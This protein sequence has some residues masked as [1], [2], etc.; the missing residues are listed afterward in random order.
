MSKPELTDST[1]VIPCSVG[2]LIEWENL[3]TVL[4]LL[5]TPGK[6]IMI[7]SCGTIMHRSIHII[8]TL[9]K[10]TE[11]LELVRSAF[12]ELTEWVPTQLIHFPGHGGPFGQEQLGTL[13]WKQKPTILNQLPFKVNQA[14]IDE[15]VEKLFFQIQQLAYFGSSDPSLALKILSQ[16]S[17][18][19][20]G[21]YSI[22]NEMLEGKNI[23]TAL[24]EGLRESA[25]D[26][27]ILKEPDILL[28]IPRPEQEAGEEEDFPKELDIENLFGESD[29]GH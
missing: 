14:S 3:P 17:A 12:Y 23:L 6:H 11:M 18:V 28:A 25:E 9:T 7:V 5:T 22:Q 10:N 1:L 2:G 15:L 20:K 27:D 29:R 19:C 16:I 26:L 4:E 24:W 21:C 13:N 8:G